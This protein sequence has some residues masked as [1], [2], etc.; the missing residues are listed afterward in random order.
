MD[1]DNLR[2]ERYQ[3]HQLREIVKNRGHFPSGGQTAVSGLAQ[4]QKDWK[5][6]RDLESGVQSIRHPVWRSIYY[7]TELGEILTGLSTQNF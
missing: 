5:M 1:A 2:H 6:P 3:A 7:C 4:Y